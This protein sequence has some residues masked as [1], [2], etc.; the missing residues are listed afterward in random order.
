M[1][2]NRMY[3]G[4]RFEFIAV[5]SNKP[6]EKGDVLDVAKRF[7]MSNKNYIFGDMDTYKLK[8]AFDPEWDASNPYTM[9]IGAKGE[10][11][12]KANKPIEPLELKRAIVKA[13][14]ELNQGLVMD[15]KKK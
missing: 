5:A 12:Y 7:Q 4:R 1:T 3:R 14:K 8:A 10:V 15:V 13:L 2:A 9:L 11:L 6:D